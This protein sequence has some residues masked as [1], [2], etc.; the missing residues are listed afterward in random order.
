[1]FSNLL[2]S[3]CNVDKIK[4]VHPAYVKI[5]EQ[6]SALDAR[7]MN[8]FDKNVSKA[9]AK[10]VMDINLKDNLKSYLK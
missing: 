4:S 5:L 9:I 3:A 1:M 6:M 10:Y 8:S 2:V 7:I